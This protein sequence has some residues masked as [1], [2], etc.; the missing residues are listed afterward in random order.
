MWVGASDQKKEGRWRWLNGEP[1]RK[2]MW[3]DGQPNGKRK[4][5]AA[6]LYESLHDAKSKETWIRGFICEW[7]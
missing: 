6:I 1:I 7:E 4:E 5:N 2:R 3:K